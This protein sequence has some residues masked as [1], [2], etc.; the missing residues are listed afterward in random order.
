MQKHYETFIE[1]KMEDIQEKLVRLH[2]R[3]LNE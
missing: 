1:E 2:E 3:Q